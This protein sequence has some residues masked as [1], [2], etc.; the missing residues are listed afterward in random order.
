[1]G[2]SRTN[3]RIL[4]LGRESGNARQRQRACRQMWKSCEYSVQI[5]NMITESSLPTLSYRNK[6]T[7]STNRA[8]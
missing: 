6:I 3:R 5:T 4:G 8:V 7:L 2:R 1:M